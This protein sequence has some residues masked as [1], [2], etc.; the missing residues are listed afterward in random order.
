[1]KRLILAAMVLACSSGRITQPI[2]EDPPAMVHAI[3]Q[4]DT[5]FNAWLLIIGSDIDHSGVTLQDRVGPGGNRCI[6]TSSIPGE[7]RFVYAAVT[8]TS[9]LDNRL[10]EL[11]LVTAAAA[12]FRDSLSKNQINVNTFFAANPGLIAATPVFDPAPLGYTPADTVAWRWT[13]T[14][15]S[16]NTIAVD[17][18]DHTCTRKL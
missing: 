15:P 3:N 17:S 14:A 12:A 5:P 2:L 4:T 8:P 9:T 6:F 11:T 10:S 7:R 18:S 13:V 16:A 1:M